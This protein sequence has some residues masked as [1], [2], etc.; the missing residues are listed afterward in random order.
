LDAIRTENWNR[1]KIGS[2]EPVSDYS[3]RMRAELHNLELAGRIQWSGR[4]VWSTHSSPGGCW[5][6]DSFGVISGLLYTLD[7]YAGLEEEQPVESKGDLI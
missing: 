3:K 7:A 4:R 5:I 1:Y 2:G 6:C